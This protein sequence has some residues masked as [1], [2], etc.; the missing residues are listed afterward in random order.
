MEMPD[1]RGSERHQSIRM[2]NG[3][4]PCTTTLVTSKTTKYRFLPQ[5]MHILEFILMDALRIISEPVAKT[6]APYI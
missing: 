6:P 5:L 4:G 2:Q 1:S 3:A